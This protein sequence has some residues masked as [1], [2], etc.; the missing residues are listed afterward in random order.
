MQGVVK[1]FNARKGFGFITD[2][3]GLDYFVHFSEI[4]QDGFRKLDAIQHVIFEPGEDG[5]GRSIAK[6]VEILEEDVCEDESE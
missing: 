2:E 3:D 6:Q 5:R 4:Q 1:W